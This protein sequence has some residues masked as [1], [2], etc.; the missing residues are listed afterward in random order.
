LIAHFI[1]IL[2]TTLGHWVWFHLLPNPTGAIN[3]I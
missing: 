2:I 3:R 1:S